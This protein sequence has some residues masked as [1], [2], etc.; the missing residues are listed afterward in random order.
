MRIVIA[1]D[2]PIQRRIL[3]ASL[4]QAGHHV[5]AFADGTAAWAQIAAHDT[6]LVM[7]DWVMPGMDGPDLIRRIRA[8]P[9]GSYTYTILLT[10]RDGKDDVVAGLAAGA[11]DYLTKPFDDRELLARIAI[12]ERLTRLEEELRASHAQLTVMATRDGLT[13]LL[14][15][16]TVHD[17]AQSEFD[18]A[19]R[20]G[21][22]C[23]VILFDIDHFKRVND[24]YGHQQ[25]DAVLHHVARTIVDNKRVYDFVGR[26]GGEEFLLVLPDCDRDCAVA[27]GERIRHA[28]AQ[29]GVPTRHGPTISVRLSGGV[30]SHTPGGSQ[31]LD[32]ILYR[33]DAALYMAKDA[34]RNCIRT[35]GGEEA[36]GPA[37]RAVS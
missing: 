8:K 10:A 23:S 4:T 7:T 6:Q 14:N 18:R 16:Q 26:W 33:A 35:W 13:G 17:R 3:V 5:D 1:E 2:D 19:R 11:D 12:G 34:G 15:R 31:P 20:Q 9:S 36:A 22:A 37:A 32:E 21:T 30:A 28:V 25:G 29:I 24:E 27:A